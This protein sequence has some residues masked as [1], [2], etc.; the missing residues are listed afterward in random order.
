MWG[1]GWA[2]DGHRVGMGRAW[3]GHGTGVCAWYMQARECEEASAVGECDE[4][5]ADGAEVALCDG[6]G[7]CG[8]SDGGS[9]GEGGGSGGGGEGESGVEACEACEEEAPAAAATPSPTAVFARKVAADPRFEVAWQRGGGEGGGEGGGKG[10]G[11][12]S[13]KGGGEAGGEGGGE[14]R[15]EGL[16]AFRLLAWLGVEADTCVL[17][18]KPSPSPSP[19]PCHVSFAR[20]LMRL[21]SPLLTQTTGSTRSCS[22]GSTE[23][24]ARGRCLTARP[25]AS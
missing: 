17:M 15:G 22:H 23:A 13:G 4:G 6:C 21:V 25:A 5:S 12:G 19:S 24:G 3:G 20:V 16:V 9:G 18:P 8:G 2:W 7:D 10:G 14:G 11:E 1:M